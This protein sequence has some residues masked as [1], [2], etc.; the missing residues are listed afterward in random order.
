[1]SIHSHGAAL[2]HNLH[3]LFS[4]PG[5]RSDQDTV[6]RTPRLLSALLSRRWYYRP[7]YGGYGN[8]RPYYGGCGGPA[9]YLAIP[10]VRIAIGGGGYWCSDEIGARDKKAPEGTPSGRFEE[11][12]TLAGEQLS[13]DFRYALCSNRVPTEEGHERAQIAAS[14]A[15]TLNLIKK[16]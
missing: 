5:S 10:P 11:S 7:T 15:A 13:R 2:P 14:A 8:C 12:P 16:R 6:A 4:T 1:M 9:F 3:D